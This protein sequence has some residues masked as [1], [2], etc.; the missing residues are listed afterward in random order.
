MIK[1]TYNRIGLKFGRELSEID[2]NK[3]T[4][5]D[6]WIETTGKNTTTTIYIDREEKLRPTGPFVCGMTFN[7]FLCYGRFVILILCDGWLM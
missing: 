1:T 3:T 2:S 6:V 4:H 5:R 7:I